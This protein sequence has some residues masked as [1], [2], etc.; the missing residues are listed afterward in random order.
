MIVGKDGVCYSEHGKAGSEG[1]DVCCEVGVGVEGLLERGANSGGSGGK[2]V[3]VSVQFVRCERGIRCGVAGD[4]SMCGAMVNWGGAGGKE[5]VFVGKVSGAVV[6]FPCRPCFEIAGKG[7]PVLSCTWG[8]VGGRMAVEVIAKSW[9]S[10][11]RRAAG[12]SLHC[13]SSNM[14]MNSRMP[15]AL[16]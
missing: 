2:V 13:A 12:A 14:L 16:V 3:E 8:V 4:G 5:L 11:I 15:S 1:R 7:F 10:D 6:G 9:S